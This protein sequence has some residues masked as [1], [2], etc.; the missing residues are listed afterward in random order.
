[1]IICLSLWGVS[2][3]NFGVNLCDFMLFKNGIGKYRFIPNF[4]LPKIRF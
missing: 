3:G 1:M 2:S 4:R